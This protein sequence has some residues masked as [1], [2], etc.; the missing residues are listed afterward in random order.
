MATGEEKK[1]E[2]AIDNT[3]IAGGNE[4]VFHLELDLRSL[5]KGSYTL[6]LK[7]KDPATKNVIHFANTG[8]ETSD[9]VP[10]GSFTLS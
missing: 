5:K 1:L 2:T 9:T 3:S 6:E 10:V 4:S 7:M 8:Y